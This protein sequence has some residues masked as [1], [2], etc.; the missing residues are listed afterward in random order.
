[1]MKKILALI[2]A[3]A[4]ALGLFG[5]G[6][7]PATSETPATPVDTGLKVG[8]GRESIAPSSTYEAHL[9]GGDWK[10]RV[11]EGVLDPVYATCIAISQGEETVLLYT[12]DL[13]LVT[14]NHSQSAK[15][16]ISQAT[17]IPED[18]IL[19]NATHTHSSVAIR[20]EWDGVQQ[21]RKEFDEAAVKAA[22]A[23]LE[24]LAPAETYAG[25]VQTD[26]LVFVRH[27]IMNDG[28]IG[29]S[30]FGSFQSGAKA[31]V[32]DADSELQLVRF[33]R[34]EK[35]PIV[36]MSFG[37]HGTFNEHQ[38]MLSADFAGPAR[39]Y[40]E[41]QLGCKVAYFMG[42]SGDQVPSSRIP[43]EAIADYQEHGQK[44]GQYAVEAIPSLA[45]I[46]GEEV[47]LTTKT[48]DVPTNKENMD[49]L[50]Q[51]QEIKSL[52]A[53]YGSSSSQVAAK[54]KEYGFA[55]RIQANWTVIRSEL[56]DTKSMDLRTLSVGNLAFVIS[57]YE[58]FGESGQQIKAQSPFATTMIIT[59]SEGGFNYIPTAAAWEYSCYESHC[60]YF[61]RGSAEKLVTEYINLLTEQK[62]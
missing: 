34:G 14:L 52:I 26:G 48:L 27:Y 29:G 31:H 61:E 56:G 42:A 4:I 24:D 47:K 2:P 16:A 36:L 11:V 1:M 51:A 22:K 49:K 25:G 41:E 32:R 55:S 17:G 30:N 10:S 39:A 9:Q 37:A 6:K 18:H 13:K 12:L 20:Y 23:A 53:S 45:K 60:S 44:L 43:G 38:N 62:G 50:A 59:C 35:E 3:A 58:M 8:F 15:T 33:D 54:V 57:P 46:E 40:V 21:Y 7:A 28:T 5:C 19:L